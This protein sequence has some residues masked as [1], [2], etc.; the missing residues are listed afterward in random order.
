LAENYLLETKQTRSENPTVG[1]KEKYEVRVFPTFSPPTA[2]EIT[3]FY[4]QNLESYRSPDAFDL[5]HIETSTPEALWAQVVATKTL[6]EFH[7]LAARISENPWTRPLGGHLGPVKRDFCLPY[8]IGLIPSLFPSLDT[9]RLGKITEPLQNPETGKWHYFWLAERISGAIKPL[10]RVKSLVEQDFL[11]NRLPNLQPKDTVAVIPGRRAILEKDVDF[12]RGEYPDQFREHSTRAN[13]V[14]YLIERE[15]VF[16]EAEA[17]GL[18]QDDR[19][20]AVRLENELSFWS[21]FYEDSLLFPSWNEDTTTLA[22]LFARKR[23]IF[24]RD[25]DSRDW[26]PF[27]RDLAAYS[28]LTPHEIETELSINRELYVRGDSLPTPAEAEAEVFQSLKRNTYQRLYAKVVSAL[29]ERFQ[30]RIDSSL[31]EPT[32]EPADKIMKQAGDLHRN[33]K[34]KQALFLYEKLQEKFP[35]SSALQST[36]GLAMAQIHFEQK[37]YQQ[38]LAEYR[39]VSLLYP[40]NPDND[41]ALF[42]E[43]FILAEYFKHDSAAVRAFEKMLEKHPDSKLSNEADWMLRNIRSGGSLVPVPQ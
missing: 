17:M 29:M 3:A 14:E 23:T 26:R 12:L 2:T 38:A 11:N 18:L 25:P 5:F 28:L 40:E 9:A 13:L 31:A 6:K 22:T 21:R 20:K 10:D 33:Q 4:N 15:V 8:G 42:M 32:Y 43:A 27:S 39:R 16:A 37:Q 30:I 35:D 41:K 19:L 1:L 36:T 7:A 24:T 34:P